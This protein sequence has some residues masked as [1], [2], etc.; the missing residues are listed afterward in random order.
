MSDRLFE[1]LSRV[2][3]SLG[4]VTNEIL[5]HSG[6]IGD[7][8]GDSVMGFWGWPIEPEDPSENATQTLLAAMN[9]RRVF[10]ETRAANPNFQDFHIGIGVASGTA[11]AGK[12]G[13][14]DQV[15]VTAFGP[16]VNLAARLE[17]MTRQTGSAVLIDKATADRIAASLV[18]DQFHLRRLGNCRPYGLETPVE[19][20]ELLEPGEL[21]DRDVTLYQQALLQFESGD[22]QG[23]W[24][25]LQEIN[26]EDNAKRFLGSYVQQQIEAGRE[27][28]GI[29]SL[30]DK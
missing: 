18:A 7:F 15:K 4:I 1:L 21:A 17:G 12:I 3:D 25:Q 9:V 2:S 23:A 5:N 10:E 16:V 22:L 20:F 19:I 8:H 28:D 11:V 6:V 27:G 26:E 14:R 13:S 29:I 30:S 24:G